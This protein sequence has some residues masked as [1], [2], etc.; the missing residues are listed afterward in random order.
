MNNWIDWKLFLPP[1]DHEIEILRKQG[2]IYRGIIEKF[3]KNWVRFYVIDVDRSNVTQISSYPHTLRPA[4][5]KGLTCS[6]HCDFNISWR[7]YEK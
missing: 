5:S 7:P 2:Y 4:L 6:L 1:A 3:N